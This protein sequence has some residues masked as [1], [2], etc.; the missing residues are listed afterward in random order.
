M[1]GMN[2][3]QIKSHVRTLSEAQVPSTKRLSLK[4]RVVE[5]GSRV[6]LGRLS[7]IIE[8]DEASLPAAFTNF[9]DRHW[10]DYKN[11]P[12]AYTCI[13][14]HPLTHLCIE[15]AVWVS[16]QSS[17]TPSA[18]P[19]TALMPNIRVDASLGDY[20]DLV[21][22]SQNQVEWLKSV[23]A[24]HIIGEDGTSLIPV[25]VLTSLSTTPGEK[26]LP[27]P[28][29]NM[30]S[31]NHADYFIASQSY[32]RLGK[33]SM[34]TRA[35]VDA[36]TQLDTLDGNKEVHLLAQ[37]Y[38]LTRLLHQYSAHGGIGTQ[39]NVAGGAFAAIIAFR[40]YY[41]ALSQD[42]QRAIP[43][44]VKQEIELLL[45]VA[46]NPEKNRD[47]VALLET[48]IGTRR[49]RL[50]NSI[51]GHEEVLSRIHISNEAQ[52]GVMRDI[53]QQLI[54]AQ[55]SLVNALANQ[56]YDKDG[57]D[58]RE[59]SLELL[60]QLNIPFIIQ[61]EEDTALLTKLSPNEIQELL[62]DQLIQQHLVT[63]L[64]HNNLLSE[65]LFMLCLDLTPEQIKPLFSAIATFV[66]RSGSAIQ[67]LSHLSIEKSM[68]AYSGLV[69][70][71]E[72]F[73][74]L[75]SY[76][77]PEQIAIV[78]QALKGQLLRLINTVDDFRTL[79][80][81]LNSEQFTVVCE[82]LKE[83]LPGLVNTGEGFR[84]LTRHFNPEQ[85]TIVCLAL[86]EKFADL[87]NTVEGFRNLT[88]HLN[89]EQ[90]TIVY[91][92][93][94]EKLPSLV[95]TAE[96]FRN[97]ISCLWPDQIT[98]FCHALKEKLPGLVNT[99]EDFGSL[100]SYLWPDQITIVCHAL[101]DQLPVLVKTAF[102]FSTLMRC[103]NSEQ[104]TAV[105]EALKD[106]LPVLVKT[107][108]DFS[109]LMSYLWPEERISI[110]KA[111]QAELSSFL[112]TKNHCVEVLLLDKKNFLPCYEELKTHLL[113]R[114][115]S[116]KLSS[117][118]SIQAFIEKKLE[119]NIDE[120]DNQEQ[121]GAAIWLQMAICR[122]EPLHLDDYLY[123]KDV[124][125]ARELKK[126]VD[127]SPEFQGLV[128]GLEEANNQQTTIQY[129]ASLQ[130]LPKTESEAQGT[131]FVKPRAN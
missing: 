100:M 50:D 114:E 92:S 71:A 64:N 116:D 44:Q 112:Q 93:L 118:Q 87:V 68:A 96:D 80:R 47:A 122:N 45:D 36:K 9:L 30:E 95:N 102:D 19:L 89:P 107:A 2:V 25:S 90:S 127:D 16:A 109:N 6:A 123:H 111:F 82:S 70:T 105:C 104:C 58:V 113:S 66:L 61:S 86:K 69:G 130:G 78:C 31:A 8:A 84:N 28:Y 77:N 17:N 97:L 121:L 83:L 85:S 128:K 29:A 32:A 18:N 39:E 54:K 14:Q 91:E 124:L 62:Q 126:I 57:A 12:F 48:C 88:R 49:E 94:K 60:Q 55:T 101:K 3:E 27:H 108:E 65:H 74:H 76:V 110:Y 37:L 22:P 79:K 23:I 106:Q 43:D 125:N 53:Q 81:Y 52:V 4:D 75:L 67:T 73:G 10:R 40:D 117:Y 72:D 24:T 33:H 34:L 131:E 59:I 46:F 120:Q 51:R 56:N 41:Q 42:A 15:L 1:H 35:I 21:A 115:N 13:P 26:V 7:T 63:Y 119:Q 20:P 129:K 38:T 99:A 11:S 103:L 5:E 98:I